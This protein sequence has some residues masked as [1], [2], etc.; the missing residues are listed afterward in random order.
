MTSRHHRSMLQ[1]PLAGGLTV[2][3][4]GFLAPFGFAQTAAARCAAA[5]TQAC[6]ARIATRLPQEARDARSWK[7]IA[8]ALARS[9]ELAMARRILRDRTG[10]KAGSDAFL[11][12]AAMDAARQKDGEKAAALIAKLK[13]KPVPSPW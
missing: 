13:K 3:S 1:A 4:A 12:A 9:G 2:I 6:V 8:L 11:L 5:P 7:I 10:A